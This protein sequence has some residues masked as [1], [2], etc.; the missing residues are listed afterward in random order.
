MPLRASRSTSSAETGRRSRALTKPLLT[1]IGLSLLGFLAIGLSGA[2]PVTAAGHSPS[3]SPSPSRFVE[4]HHIYGNGDVLS[5]HAAAN[6]EG[7]AAHIEAQGGG[8]VVVYTTSGSSNIPS[9][10]AKDWAID[11]ILVGADGDFGS[12]TIGSKLKNKLSA[13][14]FKLIDGSSSPGPATTESWILS[15]LVRVDAFV[16][17]T[18]IFDGAG[19]LDA[20]GKQQAETAAVN[21]GNQLGITVYVDIAIGGTDPSND[22]FFNGADVSNAFDKKT[23]AIALAIS[24]HTIGGYLDSTSDTW[25]T[26]NQSSPWSSNAI[27][28][29]SAPNSDNQAAILS[30][31]NAIQKPPLI[32][33]DAIPVIIF[34]V[35]TVLFSIT[36]PFIW[37]PWLIRKISGASGPIKGGLPSD[38]VIESI[39][40]TG[41]TV[42]MP[43]V[44]PEAPDYKFTL[45]VTPVGGGAPYQVVTKALVPRLF[46]PMVVPGARVGV[47]IDPANSQK[48]SIDFSR[49]NQAPMGGEVGTGIQSSA[50]GGFNMAFDAN[51]QPAANDIAALMGGVRSGGVN[52]IKGS[53][54]HLLATGTHGTAVI[55][56]AMPLGQKVRDAD[57]AAEA[58]HLDDPL[59]LFT[60]EVSLA[61]QTP[62]PAVFGHRVPVAKL[63]SVAPGVKLAVA[64]DEANKNQDVAIDW[65]KSPIAG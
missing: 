44:G 20:N 59:W 22:A 38:A 6:A 46:V 13:N 36:A 41:V 14:Q 35:V 60:V 52:Q 24:G 47:L 27:E 1:A 63:A 5:S 28:N 53:A 29:W 10:L 48:I 50:P 40:D 31:I 65:D 51:G 25:N 34:V 55:T 9:T 57:P 39:A 12:L 37:G 18:H 3:P 21:L 2:R 23:L 61:G 16:S 58:S 15:T 64:V 54:A 17:G 45:Q 43:S 49:I 11:G 62:F 8:R 26:Y 32:P 4:G 56:T 19:V 42:S 30:A 7:L 33:S